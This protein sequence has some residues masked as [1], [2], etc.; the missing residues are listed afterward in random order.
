V[1]I[2][3]AESRTVA[4][5]LETAYDETIVVPLPDIFGHRHLAGGTQKGQ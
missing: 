5:P 4:V 3:V 2:R 1:T